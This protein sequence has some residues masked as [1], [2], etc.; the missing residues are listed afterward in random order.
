MPKENKT[1]VVVALL[2][3]IWDRKSY[4]REIEGG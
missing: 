2:N 1:F 4:Y 3:V